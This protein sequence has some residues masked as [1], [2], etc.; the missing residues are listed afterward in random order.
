MGKQAFR[1]VEDAY[2][3]RLSPIQPCIVR[4]DGRAFSKLAKPFD[5]PFDDVFVGAM[6]DVAVALATNVDDCVLAYVQSDEV[7]LVLDAPEGRTPWFSWRVQKLTS[8]TASIAS[9]TFQ[10]AMLVADDRHA[11]TVRETPVAFDARAFSL[12]ADAVADYL[13]WRQTDATRNAISQAAY[14]VVG[15]KATKGLRCDEMQEALF[16]SGVNFDDY[17]P[18]LKRGAVAFRETYEKLGT[19]PRTGERVPCIRH[20]WVLDDEPPIFARDAEYLER[21]LEGAGLKR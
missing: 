14:H 2:A 12:P 19:D 1:D 7:S 16:E 21:L 3:T 9:V 6:D 18:R 4:V 8:V 10:K 11:R 15:A 5:R 20:R 13:V 17:P